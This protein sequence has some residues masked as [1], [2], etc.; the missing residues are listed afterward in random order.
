MYIGDRWNNKPDG[1]TGIGRNQWYPLTFDSNGMPIINGYAQWSLDAAAG[2]W[3]PSSAG[4]DV[5]QNYSIT[6][7]SSGK[8]LGI[9]GNST[10][11]SAMVE[12]RTL[13]GAAGQSWQFVD[14][15]D[16]Y[17]KIKNVNSGKFMNISGASTAEG[18][19]AIQYTSS[20]S[21]NQ[22]WQLIS[23]GDGYYKIKNRNSGKVLSVS[24][25]SGADG[26]LIVQGADA[27]AWSQNFKFDKF[28]PVDVAKTYSIINRNSG[29]A[30]GVSGNSTA[31]GATIV[32]NVY[33]TAVSQSWQF[34]DA[35]TGYFKIK[36][37]NSGKVMDING[38]SSTD[39]AQNIQWTDNGG[40][41][42]KWQLIDAG[43]GYYK[44]KNVN[45]GK[46]LGMSGGT[47]ADGGACIQWSETGSLNQNWSFNVLA[48]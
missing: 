6:N 31:D 15:G 12:Q 30:L 33:G 24:G 44:I 23:V 32:Q 21:T 13:T 2:T 8:A 1:S 28:A 42:Q 17:F 11:D 41:N 27:N 46:V 43:G 47:T 48:P 20:T 37:V 35:G 9:V 22:Q 18:A 40:T 19:Q 5:T 7:R 4:I 25:S 14:T 16:G 26:A 36:N 10:A 34:I 45:S 38:A 39:G 3:S 29:K